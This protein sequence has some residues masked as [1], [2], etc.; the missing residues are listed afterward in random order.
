MSDTS[1]ATE[2]LP[3]S[4]QMLKWLVIVLTVSMIGGVITIVWLLV[5]HLPVL[6]PG[7]TLPPALDL[8]AGTTASAVTMGRDWIGVVTSDDRIL[9]FTPQGHL[10]Q[11]IRIAPATGG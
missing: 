3:P 6:N 4:L 1:N 8:P 10:R 5:T 11:E 2:R 7:P 9:I